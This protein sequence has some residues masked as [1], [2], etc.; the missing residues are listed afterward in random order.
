MFWLIVLLAATS[1]PAN[2]EFNNYV[3]KNFIRKEPVISYN[4]EPGATTEL[5]ITV[6]TGD[7]KRLTCAS[8]QALEGTHC[9]FNADKRKP[10]PSA[11]DAPIDDNFKDTI[12]P[13]RTLAHNQLVM[14]SGL[15]AQ[16]EIAM[17]VHEELPDALP[18]KKQA[19]FTALCKVKMLGK[20]DEVHVR[21][22]P[23]Q[24]WYT[25]KN[26]PV[27]RAESCRIEPSR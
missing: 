22:E 9:A 11:P 16:P 27:A 17:R 14:V 4:L 25:E 18:V 24:Q 12:Q 2:S 15:W 7:S 13:Y 6:V 26:V 21:W 8:D 20:M 3:Q 23:G 1:L 19:R 10:W 5:D